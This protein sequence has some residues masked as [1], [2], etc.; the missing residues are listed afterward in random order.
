MAQPKMKKKGANTSL[1]FTNKMYFFLIPALAF[2]LI[3]WI[4][5]VLQLF[6][7]SVTNFNGVNYNFDF[8]GMKNY[9]KVLNNGTLTNSMKNT[10]IYAVVTVLLSNV[11]GLAV[12]MILNTKIHFKG[13]FRTCAAV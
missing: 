9:L 8:V 3:F 7:Y 13:L 10:L 11:V 6:Y 12:A 4:Y 1:V 2:F 5:P